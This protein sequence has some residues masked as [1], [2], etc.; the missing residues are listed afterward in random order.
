MTAVESVGAGVYSVPG[1][2]QP[3]DPFDSVRPADPDQGWNAAR[4]LL[5]SL[6]HLDLMRS[7]DE[8]A[9]RLGAMIGEVPSAADL[10]LHHA[11][12]GVNERSA[13]RE[14]ATSL[15]SGEA[16]TNDE[17]ESM[18]SMYA[19]V[20]H[21]EFHPTDRCNLA[22]K[23]CT[24]GHDVA[25]EKPDPVSFP[26]SQ[27][28]RIQDL[29]PASIVIVGGGE[30]TLYKSEGR[31]FAEMVLEL[32]RILPTTKFALITNGTFVPDGNWT[33]ELSWVRLSV[34][35]ANPHTY[36]L[37]RGRPML[38]RVMRGFTRYLDFEHSPSGSEFPLQQVQY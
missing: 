19:T 28:H 2:A 22:C 8:V 32:R 16:T 24:Y 12:A 31:R 13:I 11:R 3:T 37:V 23:G 34:D 1:E 17:F 10:D 4:N 15:G 9:S 14:I 5:K 21:M 30:P 20:A 18:L 26:F 35:A 25:A 36:E 29:E 7:K 27:L 6:N 38:E 33:D